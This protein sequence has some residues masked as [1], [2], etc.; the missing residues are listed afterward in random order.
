LTPRVAKPAAL[1]IGVLLLALA[2]AGWF[3][4]PVIGPHGFI[5]A[6][7]AMAVGH[8]ILG[9]YLLAMSL[10]GESTCAFALYSAAGVC[11][12]FAAYG[13]FEFSGRDGAVL[14][15]VTYATTSS[16]YFH[17]GLGLTMAI[18]AKLNTARKQLFRE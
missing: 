10:S 1:W 13:L 18:L 8:G 7:R 15:N 14:F 3:G 2:V 11:V 4:G 5:A 6:D 17:L 9:L 12:L 16:E